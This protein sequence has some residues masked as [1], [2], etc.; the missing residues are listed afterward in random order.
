MDKGLEPVP[1][2]LG[3]GL[4]TG[5]TTLRA[6]SLGLVQT[7]RSQFELAHDCLVQHGLRSLP[8]R[9]DV[10]LVDSSGRLRFH[11]L[12][13]GLLQLLEL[14]VHFADGLELVQIAARELVRANVHGWH[15]LLRVLRVGDG[16]VGRE[17]ALLLRLHLLAVHGDRALVLD[18]GVACVG[19]A[20]QA[21]LHV[22]LGRVDGHRAGAKP[23]DK[24]DQ[25]AKASGL[26]ACRC[27][28][29]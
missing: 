22:F 25:S 2:G 14:S 5:A 21:A 11:V 13:D 3:I 9:A 12:T 1:W 26:R 16:H 23:T 19:G 29:R 18:T 24:T 8:Q 4:D 28:Y 10:L 17:L 15:H 7:L 6:F 27:H 20:A